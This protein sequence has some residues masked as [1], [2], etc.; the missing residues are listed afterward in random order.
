M[1]IILWDIDGTL[2]KSSEYLFPSTHLQAL[3]QVK[4][5]RFQKDERLPGA[6]DLEVILYLAD[7]NDTEVSKK[8]SMDI[9]E[10]L[11]TIAKHKFSKKRA[12]DGVVL[13]GVKQMLND[14]KYYDFLQG[15]VTGNT[16]TRA[17][18]K[19][20]ASQLIDYFKPDLIFCGGQFESR[21][22]FVRNV[23]N[24]LIC[25]DLIL[26]GDSDRDINAAKKNGLEV[27]GI[28]TGN[29]QVKELKQMN[30]DFVISNLKTSKVK[31]INFLLYGK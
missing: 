10:E 6:T 31:F 14:L 3:S 30:P 25:E 7:I 4:K 12:F 28:A 26:I 9:L 16:R 11:D 13:P 24:K 20:E 8:E 5:I 21:V 18:L 1:K 29:F 19:L 15:I 23:K 2:L 22:K 27:I 17:R